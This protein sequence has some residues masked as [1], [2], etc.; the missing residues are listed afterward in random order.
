MDITKSEV[1]SLIED[2]SLEIDFL[3]ALVTDKNIPFTDKLDEVL[4]LKTVTMLPAL[5]SFAKSE[6]SKESRRAMSVAKSLL[7][8]LNDIEASLYTKRT[9][10]LREDIDFNHPKVQKAFEIML[11][12]TITSMQEAGI[13]PLAI[14]NFINIFGIATVGFEQELSVRMK[15]ISNK[16]IDLLE[17]PLV[18]RYKTVKRYAETEMSELID[19]VS[20]TSEEN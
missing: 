20:K 11:E 9:Y 14:N 3:T 17:N 4:K 5:K 13:E 8:H 2:Y 10:E 19:K 12:T 1:K 15:G 6:D 18:T 16:S 7:I